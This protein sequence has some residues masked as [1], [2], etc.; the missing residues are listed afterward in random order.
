MTALAAEPVLVGVDL[1]KDFGSGSAK[2]SIV[3]DC[4][5]AVSAAEFVLLMGPSGSGKTTLV[6]M[7]GGLLRPTHGSVTLCGHRISDYDEERA[8]RVRRE[9]LG[10]I[11]QNYKLFPALT[12]LENVA[13]VLVL[14][15]MRRPDARERALEVLAEVGLAARAGH[16][17]AQ[18]SGGQN[19]RVA[20][21]RAIAAR[22][23][24]LIGDEVTA[25]LDS[26]SAAMIMELLSKYAAAQT[27]VLLVTHDHRLDTWA[28]RVLNM[29]DGRVSSVTVRGGLGRGVSGLP[30]APS[31]A[32]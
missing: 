13:E 7:L 28:N 32:P 14:K 8:A 15:G 3:H 22:P 27:A 26:E 10:F 5:C 29:V 21:A 20:I 12:A 16:R 23:R 19:Q 30:L 24:L 4:S 2:S 1:R 25:A 31:Q 6:S 18:L 17:P 11:F 9:N